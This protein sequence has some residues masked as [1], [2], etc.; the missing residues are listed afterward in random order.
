MQV[1]RILWVISQVQAVTCTGRRFKLTLIHM[2]SWSPSNLDRLFNYEG[3]LRSKYLLPKSQV[4]NYWVHG[5]S[6]VWKLLIRPFCRCSIMSHAQ[7]HSDRTSASDLGK[8]RTSTRFSSRHG[9]TYAKHGRRGGDTF[10]TRSR[11]E[12]TSS[13][14]HAHFW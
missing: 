12:G 10:K 13:A 4:P 3:I 5:P 14:Y 9:T 8:V 1:L 11:H 6:G 7:W 2:Q